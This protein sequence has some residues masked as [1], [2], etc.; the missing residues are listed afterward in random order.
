MHVAASRPETSGRCPQSRYHSTLVYGHA[1]VKA[2]AVDISERAE[3]VLEPKEAACPRPVRATATSELATALRAII[4]FELTPCW[5][6]GWL[7]GWLP[8]WLAG[9][10]GVKL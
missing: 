2:P 1:H 8:G 10:L 3:A 5:L 7:A 4:R 6:G 9:W